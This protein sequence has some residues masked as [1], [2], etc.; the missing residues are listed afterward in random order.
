MR[1]AAQEESFRWRVRPEGEMF[2]GDIHHNVSAL[3]GPSAE[4]MRCGWSCVVLDQ[5]S[6]KVVASTSGVP[7]PWISCIDGS[8]TWAILGALLDRWDLGIH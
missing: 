8:E 3:D 1:Y 5:V 4:L 6:G 2:E 7:P